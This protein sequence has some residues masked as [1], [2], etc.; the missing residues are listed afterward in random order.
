MNII[1]YIMVVAAFIFLIL[2]LSSYKS[3]VSDIP[4]GL[5][6]LYAQNKTQPLLSLNNSRDGLSYTVNSSVSEIVSPNNTSVSPYSTPYSITEPL[7]SSSEA[8]LTN[9]SAASEFGNSESFMSID[10]SISRN[11]VVLNGSASKP[12]A[13]TFANESSSIVRGINIK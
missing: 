3:L 9:Y 11:E 13:T 5:Y 2:S 6:S 7:V 4:P 10:A 12:F 8:I 1:R